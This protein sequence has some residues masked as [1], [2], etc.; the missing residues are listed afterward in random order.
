MNK[1]TVIGTMAFGLTMLASSVAAEFN[2]HMY[3]LHSLGGSLRLSFGPG[4]CQNATSAAGNGVRVINF[5][6]DTIPVVCMNYD[7]WNQVSMV[8]SY[9]GGAAPV[10]KE[11]PEGEI[12]EIAVD[13]GDSPN[14]TVAYY[15]VAPFCT[16]PGTTIEG[17]PLN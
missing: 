6:A 8:C 9:E 2:I 13:V 12:V 3:K 15:T 5:E 10:Y 4:G 11:I 14:T 16:L 17:G 7:G 1:L